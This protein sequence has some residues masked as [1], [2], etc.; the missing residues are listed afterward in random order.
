MKAALRDFELPRAACDAINQSVLGVDA[1][2]PVSPPAL[3]QRL[4]LANA[5]ERIAINDIVDELLDPCGN[6]RIGLLPIAKVF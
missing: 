1:A 4:R 2:R 5:G 6:L 3:S